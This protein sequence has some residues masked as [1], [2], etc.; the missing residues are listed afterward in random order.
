MLYFAMECAG[1]LPHIYICT[2]LIDGLSKD[3]HL[4]KARSLFEGLPSKGL[5]PDVKTYTVMIGAFCREGL[6]DEANE[7]FAKMK[8][9]N[10]LPDDATYNTLIRGSFHNK[11]YNEASVIIDEMCARGFSADASTMSLLPVLLESK[12]QDSALL[13]LRK[14]YLT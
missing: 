10:C 11:K 3:G 2:I 12:D 5:R 1:V 13:A 6:L 7:L 9:S 4:E 14:K 8:D